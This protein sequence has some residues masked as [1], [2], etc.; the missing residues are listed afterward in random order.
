MVTEVKACVFYYKVNSRS[1]E[2]YVYIGLPV[3]NR[4][5]KLSPP[6]MALFSQKQIVASVIAA[7]SADT[8]WAGSTKDTA[9]GKGSVTATDYKVYNKVCYADTN[10]NRAQL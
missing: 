6:T 2:N 10:Y 9:T 3:P 5:I 1:I 8:L 7:T 4:V